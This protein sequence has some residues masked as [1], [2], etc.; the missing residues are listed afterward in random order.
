MTD[1]E[2]MYHQTYYQK[3]KEKCKQT[4][5][6]SYYK[7]REIIKERMVKYNHDYYL[8]NRTKLLEK[9]RESRDKLMKKPPKEKIIP[10]KKEK[11]PRYNCEACNYFDIKRSYYIAHLKT[12]RHKK[13]TTPIEPSFVDKIAIYFD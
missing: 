5:I 7:N 6:E 1:K 2:K 4:A 9:M 13:N 10:E 12:I 11:I 3:N 8:K